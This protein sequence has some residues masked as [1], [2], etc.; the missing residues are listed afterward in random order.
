[1]FNPFYSRSPG[2]LIRQRRGSGCYWLFRGGRRRWRRGCSRR[3]TYVPNV[4]P[5]LP[6]ITLTMIN[7]YPIA[8]GIYRTEVLAFKSRSPFPA[9][10]C[11]IASRS[12]NVRGILI[13]RDDMVAEMNLLEQVCIMFLNGLPTI[14]RSCVIHQNRILRV[15]RGKPGGIAVIECLVFFFIVRGKRLA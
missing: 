11:F 10:P 3:W 13:S 5:N 1:M 12:Y 15:E 9:G 2:V 4:Q 14:N 6:I 8:L 7:L